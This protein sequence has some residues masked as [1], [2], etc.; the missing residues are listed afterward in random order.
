MSGRPRI[1][2]PE[3][4]LDREQKSKGNII[5]RMRVMRDLCNQEAYLEWEIF[6]LTGCYIAEGFAF[7]LTAISMQGCCLDVNCRLIYITENYLLNF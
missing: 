1:N 3:S 4:Y 2:K 5:T 7:A 6:H